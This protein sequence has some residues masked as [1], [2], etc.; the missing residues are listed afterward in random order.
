MKKILLLAVLILNINKVYS[1]FDTLFWFVAPEVLNYGYDFDR[2]IVFRI[3]TENFASTVTI[4]FP[5]NPLLTPYVIN[6]GANNTLTQDVTTYINDLE[7]IQPNQVLNKGIRIR[8]TQPVSVYYEVVSSIQSFCTYCSPDIFTLKGQKALGT[9]FYIP[10][11]TVYPNGTSGSYAAF[12]I[13]ATEDNTFVTIT[14]SQNIVGATAGNPLTVVLNKGQTFSARSSSQQGNLKPSGSK[15]ISN[16][17]IA[18][19]IKDDLVLISS[20]Q[21]LAGDQLVPVDYTGTEYI[22][23]KGNLNPFD[24]VSI[25]AT[26]D[27]TNVVINGTSVATLNEG[28][29]FTYNLTINCIYIQTTKKTY[30]IHLTGTG[31][32][33]SLAVIPALFF[34][35]IKQ[36]GFTRPSADDLFLF[37]IVK[38]GGEGSFVL[39]GNS[40]LFIPADFS[41]VPNTGG[42]Y[43]YAKKSFNTSTVPSNAGSLIRNTT[44]PFQ[45]ALLN[46]RN[47]AGG[48]RYAYFSNFEGENNEVDISAEKAALCEGDTI[49]LYGQTLDPNTVSWTGPNGFTSNQLNIVIPNVSPVHAGYYVFTTSA[50]ACGSGKDSVYITIASKPIKPTV[51]SNLP[52]C[53]GEKLILKITNKPGFAHTVSWDK[54]AKRAIGIDDSLVFYPTFQSDEAVYSVQY[55]SVSNG[56][57]SDTAQIKVSLLPLPDK[58]SI[59]STATKYCEFDHVVISNKT[60]VPLSTQFSW[61]GEHGFSSN[62]RNMIDLDSIR[63]GQSGWYKLT[64]IDSNGCK[65]ESDLIYID[66]IPYPDLSNVSIRS[67][68]PIC[69]GEPLNLKVL[70]IDSSLAVKWKGPSGFSST[71]KDILIPNTTTA[72]SGIYKLSVSRDICEFSDTL[73]TAVLVR[74][75]PRA[76]FDF[77]PAIARTG[78]NIHFI[79]KSSFAAAYEWN[80]GD[81]SDHSPAINPDHIYERE[82]RLYITLIAYNIDS[83]CIDSSVKRLDV[84]NSEEGVYVPSAFSPNNDGNNDI[85]KVVATGVKFEITLEVYNRW[86]GLIFKTE[87]AR[88]IGW[89]GT[90][91]DIPCQE[92]VYMYVVRYISLEDKAIVTSGTVTLLR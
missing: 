18:I 20:C 26:E 46:G 22:V 84:Y 52:V 9:K 13:V 40:T 33:G 74:Q 79:N 64:L 86:G 50:P 71:L 77:F 23:V 90:N 7:N 24:I 38:N 88:N 59:T 62:L 34:S 45:F 28:Q 37:V 8:A 67:N 39:N 87:D 14:P 73:Q 35:C 72:M 53:L 47:S 36:Y 76:D 91:S 65:N 43:K 19:T 27:N 82:E 68:S 4:D 85:F 54:G 10:F 89:D 75:T 57:L 6:I 32:E 55:R 41:N 66:V 5:A 51:S 81:F 80:F 44:H 2:P 70:N 11:Q 15:V 78:R 58:P 60:T 21:D 69:S 12:D 17:P 49:R 42:L 31:C 30:V 61:K 56:C 3:S 92:G 63:T 16:K 48:S 83:T 29:T 25:L 1:Q